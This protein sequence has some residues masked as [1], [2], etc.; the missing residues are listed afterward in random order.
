IKLQER[1]EIVRKTL[2]NDIP[3]EILSLSP[4]EE[5]VQKYTNLLFEAIPKLDGDTIKEVTDSQHNLLSAVIWLSVGNVQMIFG[6][7]LEK[8]DNNSTGWQRIV[9]NRDSPDLWAQAVKVPHHGSSGAFCEE[10]WVKHISNGRPI[11]IT[12]P[13]TKL[14]DPLPHRDDLEQINRFAE[15]V[16]VTALPTWVTAKKVYDRNIIKRAHEGGLRNWKAF[17][18]PEKIGYVRIDMSAEN[19]AERN[20]TI[21]PPAYIYDGGSLDIPT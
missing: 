9:D 1:T 13:Y 2:Y 17:I 8:G 21:E 3:V 19:G 11:A 15:P 18:E 6:S 20:I 7:D 10:A 16:I 14:L 5:S 12:T 4:S